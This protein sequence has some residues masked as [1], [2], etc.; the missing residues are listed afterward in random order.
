MRTRRF[1]SL[2]RCR[3]RVGVGLI[4]AAAAAIG[5]AAPAEGAQRFVTTS[6]SGSFCTQATPCS[7]V[8]GINSAAAND[9]VI[10]ASGTYNTSTQLL[11]NATDLDIHGPS[12]AAKP[13]IN[14]TASSALLVQ[15][16]SPRLADLVIN[17]IGIG[18]GLFVP[19]GNADIERLSVR[20]T[21]SYACAPAVSGVVRDTT[22]VATGVNAAAIN[23]ISGGGTTTQRLRNVTAIATGTNGD[24]LLVGTLSAGTVRVVDARNVIFSGTQDIDASASG[25]GSSV[26]VTAQSSNYDSTATLGAATVTTPGSGTNQTDAPIFADTTLYHQAPSSPTVNAGTTDA[27]TGTLDLDGD[28]RPQ[29]AA[30]DI[31]ADELVPVVTPPQPPA[32]ATPPETTIDKGPK[33]KSRKRKAKFRFSSNEPGST[34]TC[35]VDRKPPAP[36]TSPLKLKRLKRGKHKLTVTATDAAGNADASPATYSWKVKKKRKRKR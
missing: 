6:G 30:I 35:A 22:C 34:F 20:S 14:S 28:T 32:D 1:G 31:G 21:G 18:A 5:V 19:V 7:L 8:T 26:T 9:E 13:V 27:F 36:C 2:S 24:G 16:T 23:H 4:A 3:G 25:A 33:R 17:H 29:G 11:T 15:G 10:I 12:P